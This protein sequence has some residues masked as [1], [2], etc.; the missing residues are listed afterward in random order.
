MSNIIYAMIVLH[1]ASRAMTW[2]PWLTTSLVEVTIW[3]DSAPALMIMSVPTFGFLIIVFVYLLQMPL[4]PGTAGY[5]MLVSL[6]LSFIATIA[7][8]YLNMNFRK[9]YAVSL[10][11]AEKLTI[12]A[13]EAAERQRI[14]VK[15]MS[16]QLELERLSNHLTMSALA[17]SIAHEINQPLSALVTNASA[18]LR[19]LEAKNPEEARAAFSQVIEEG[20]RAAAVIT[21]MRRLLRKHDQ[22]PQLVDLKGLVGDAINITAQECQRKEVK[23]LTEFAPSPLKVFGDSIQLQQLFINLIKN[24][25]DAMDNISLSQRV[26]TVAGWESADNIMLSFEDAGSGIPESQRDRIFDAFYTTKKDGMG[27]GLAICKSIVESMGGQLS[28][29]S[30]SMGTAFLISFPCAVADTLRCAS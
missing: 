20:N 29:T 9:I 21:S 14:E 7:L 10:A 13:T 26:I 18:G 12:A 4:R 23:I 15:L 25:I 17:A 5:D 16:T 24:G 19:W 1:D 30:G 11:R 8:L 27:M 22:E 2:V 28:I 3:F 6:A